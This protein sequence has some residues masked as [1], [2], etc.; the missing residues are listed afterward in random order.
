MPMI[1][2]SKLSE[3]VLTRRKLFEKIMQNVA[4]R[5][6]QNS[7]QAT[8]DRMSVTP[9]QFGMQVGQQ[10]KKSSFAP[11]GGPQLGGLM[12]DLQHIGGSIFADSA[13]GRSPLGS[14]MQNFGRVQNMSRTFQ[15]MP[16]MTT[17]GASGGGMQNQHDFF[18]NMKNVFSGMPKMPPM[19][20]TGEAWRPMQNMPGM[21]TMPHGAGA[22]DFSMKMAGLPDF[23]EKLNPKGFRGEFTQSQLQMLPL[24]AAGVGGAGGA[25]FSKRKN[26]L[27][28][29]IVGALGGGL[30][31]LGASAG[32]QLGAH[33]WA[34]TEKALKRFTPGSAAAFHRRGLGAGLFGGAAGA[35]L[36]ADVVRA[37]QQNDAEDN[38]DDAVVMRK[39][40]FADNKPIIKELKKLSAAGTKKKAS[41]LSVL[42]GL[43][44]GG[45]GG[46]AGG[47]GGGILGALGGGALGGGPGAGL[48]LLAGGA[49]GLG[50]G[51]HMGGNIGASIGAGFSKKKE[52]PESEEKEEKSEEKSESSGDEEVKESAAR[53][54]AQLQK[55]AK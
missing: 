23:I 55:N 13:A 17:T 54:L 25:L 43:A 45:L 44:G 37:N 20:G 19:M 21:P 49:A 10:V 30:T 6:I 33:P 29:A 39:N 34:A 53:V 36:T 40:T 7:I 8:G 47:A 42:G 4:T 3:L 31:G 32:Y 24:V 5:K 52:K 35:A 1:P 16:G 38:E 2:P 51:A 12:D 9:Q 15:N 14:V 48:G 46:L 18:T 22:P 41:V 27:R 11:G 26:K 28:N 50:A